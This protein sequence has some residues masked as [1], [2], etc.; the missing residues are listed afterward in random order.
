VTSRY[1]GAKLRAHHKKKVAHP[2]K[3]A[4]ALAQARLMPYFIR[5]QSSYLQMLRFAPSG[6]AWQTVD[7]FCSKSYLCQKITNFPH[8]R[9]FWKANR[10]FDGHW[11]LLFKGNALKKWTS[12]LNVLSFCVTQASS[13]ASQKLS[14]LYV[15]F[16]MGEVHASQSTSHT[17]WNYLVVAAVG[18][19]W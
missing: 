2:L 6:F 14:N 13:L 19:L 16:K 11:C 8:I 9:T 1:Y 5:I 12:D 10:L 3:P 17:G 18:R 15:S 7:A 4:V